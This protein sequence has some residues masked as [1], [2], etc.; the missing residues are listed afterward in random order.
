MCEPASARALTE[1]I[2]TLLT[3]PALAATLREQAYHHAQQHMT[4]DHMMTGMLATY[5]H[6][7]TRAGRKA[8]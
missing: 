2:D 8:G 1:A 6:A 7:L 3:D 4:F 5:Q